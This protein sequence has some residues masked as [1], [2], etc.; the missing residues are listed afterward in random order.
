MVR[1]AE[2]V[3]GEHFRAP[4][5]SSSCAAVS[6]STQVSARLQAHRVSYSLIHISTPNGSILMRSSPEGYQCDGGVFDTESDR[7]EEDRP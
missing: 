6:D 5:M 7:P 4:T 3:I 2:Q 1:Y